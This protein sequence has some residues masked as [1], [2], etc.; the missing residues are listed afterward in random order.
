MNLSESIK[1][2]FPAMSQFA[3]FLVA[4]YCLDLAVF[5]YYSIKMG[6][7]VAEEKKFLVAM[8]GASFPFLLYAPVVSRFFELS[9]FNLCYFSGHFKLNY[10]STTKI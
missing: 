7:P 2:N 1:A 6:Q 10:A 3:K 8:E 9:L 4:P 5:N